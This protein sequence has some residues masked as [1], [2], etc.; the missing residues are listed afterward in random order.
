MHSAGRSRN[1]LLGTI[2]VLIIAGPF[3]LAASN[4]PGPAASAA[5]PDTVAESPLIVGLDQ[6]AS[7]PRIPGAR[8]I[9]LAGMDPELQGEFLQVV[10]AVAREYGLDVPY[11]LPAAHWNEVTGAPSAG[12]HMFAS[13]LGIGFD[14]AVWSSETSKNVLLSLARSPHAAANGKSFRAVVVHEMGHVLLGQRLGIEILEKRNPA[15]VLVE[16]YRL[17]QG[18]DAVI[19]ELGHYAWTGSRGRAQEAWQETFAEAF[20]AY[21]LD[22]QSTSATTRALVMEVFGSLQVAG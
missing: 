17:E 10:A 7:S 2:G 21:Y 13:D 8:R 6:M 12:G 20:A 14:P 5:V 1:R 9:D 22:P 18:A 15:R 3:V 19:Q 16:E 11:I 4:A